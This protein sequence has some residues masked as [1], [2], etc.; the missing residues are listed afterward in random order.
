[1]AG[2]V[3]DLKDNMEFRADHTGTI[4]IHGKLISGSWKINEKGNGVIFTSG[5][6][7]QTFNISIFKIDN[8]SMLVD[9]P[10]S[11]GFIRFSYS[12]LQK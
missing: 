1:M 5:D 7:T 6:K 9:E 3:K 11:I 4:S 12:R 10:S 2:L 8:Y